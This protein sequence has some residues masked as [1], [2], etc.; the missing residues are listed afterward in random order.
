MNKVY[1]VIWSEAH[2]TWVVVAEGTKRTCKSSSKTIKLLIAV[3]ATSAPL[4][5]SAATLP[6]GGSVSFGEGSIAANGSNQLTIKQTSDKLGI[7]WQSFNI[8]ADG[9]VVFEQ[10]GAK[11]VALNRVLGSDGSSIMGKLN[12][13]GQVFIINPNGI[14]FGKTAKVNVGGLVA[15]TL[16][17]SDAD[18]QVVNYKFTTGAKAGAVVNHGTLQAAEGGYVALI[19]KSVQNHGTIQARLGTASLAAGDAVT[20]DFSGDGLINLRV[21]KAAVGALVDNHGLIVADGGKVLMTARAANAI[22]ET[23]VNND[24]I[25]QAQ[26][27][28]M[29]AGKIMLDGG[30]V[31]GA[32]VVTVGGTLDASAHDVGD[33]GFIETSG[34]TV[35]VKDGA[36]ITTKAEKG[37]TGDWLID[38]TDFTVTAGTAPSTASGIGAKT[39]ETALAS[40][41]VTL[42]TSSSGTEDGNL[43]INGAFAW[44]ANT[45]LT[46]KAHKSVIINSDVAINGDAGGISI[47]YGL[48]G[49]LSSAFQ[50]NGGSGTL[51]MNGGNNTFAINGINYIVIDDTTSLRAFSNA[52][53]LNGHYVLAK[54]INAVSS[55]SWNGGLGF[56]PIGDATHSFT[57][58][59]EGLNHRITNLTI[60]RPT[61]DY[62]GFFAT[63]SGAKISGLTLSGTVTG[64]SNVGLLAGKFT[65]SSLLAY[66]IGS[67]SY[68]ISNFSGSVAG[69]SNVG[70]VFGQTSGSNL[71]SV[72]NAG[73]VSAASGTNVGGIFGLGTSLTGKY[74]YNTGTI[75]GADNIGGIGGSVAGNSKIIWS[76]NQGSINGGSYVGGLFGLM[77]NSTLDTAWSSGDVTASG[78]RS[79]GLI[80][81]S[82][83]N[84]V[85]KA[86]AT[87]RVSALSR[88]AGGIIGYDTGGSTVSETFATS[89]VS[90]GDYS[91]GL[92][93]YANGATISSSYATGQ[94][95]GANSSGLVSGLDNS[96]L[97]V[98]Y[99]SGKAT[100]GLI[101][102]TTSGSNTINEALWD[103]GL[104]ATTNSLYGSGKTSAQMRS[105]STFSNWGVDVVGT[106]A[107]LWRMYDGKGAPLLKFRL[108]TGT[109]YTTVIGTSKNATYA[110]R[111]LT[112]SD[113]VNLGISNGGGLIFWGAYTPITASETSGGNAIRN[114]GVYTLDQMYSDQF[115]FN[116]YQ[117]TPLTLAVAKKQLTASAAASVSK[118]Y[119]GTTG[120]SFDG[121]AGTYAGDD[122]AIKLTGN[123][124]DKNAGGGKAI[125]VSNLDITGAAAS[126]YL[127]TADTNISGAVSKA[128]LILQGAADD[129]TYDGTTQAQAILTD[130]RIAGDNLDFNFAANFSDKNAGSSKVVSI[131]GIAV[132]GSDAGNY[133]WNTSTTANAT[134][135][136]AVLNVSAH[137]SGKTYDGSTSASVGL[138]DNRVLGDSLAITAWGANFS[139]KNAGNGKAVNV[140]GINVTGTDVGNYTWNTAATTSANIDKAHLV[141]NAENGTKVEGVMDGQFKWNLQSGTLFGSDS[142]QGHLARDAG[143]DVGHYGIHEGDLTAG[144]N[145]ELSVVPGSFEITKLAKP[146]VISDPITPPVVVKPVDP[147]NPPV[148]DLGKPVVNAD[149]ESAKG[150]ISTVS[151]ATNAS[152]TASE[153]MV[154]ANTNTSSILADYRLL[155]LGMKLPDDMLSDEASS[156]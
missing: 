135:D 106:S 89:E 55:S 104:S 54:N 81:S 4:A 147:V 40:S 151:V 9:R 149:L 58:V 74:L 66:D 98:V 146:P 52:P 95:S 156:F 47:N 108:G 152:R 142:I 126:N 11:S 37:R 119:D 123:F 5:V 129:K 145:Y 107:G 27:I 41:N 69:I 92:I 87:G 49:D 101:A 67:S 56:D 12:A 59:F 96:S 114:A 44:S 65:N 64:N 91:G 16:D 43:T 128:N 31:D 28:N 80:G 42:Q 25:I 45:T 78:E 72:Q 2:R 120:I 83:Q 63:T 1:N 137:A 68:S 117:P 38:P 18:F 3:I 29:R 35:S 10:P 76:R 88:Y 105:A 124:A 21:D 138:D 148:V 23:V 19:G 50:I 133:T 125:N 150:I 46:L 110:G 77:A 122:L 48:G 8:G 141:V 20:L 51:T 90:A 132:A 70:G 39:L 14:I 82:N 53:V 103:M 99:A 94:V 30:P 6:Q 34:K 93:G 136:K 121:I 111:D 79:G 97:N 144:S 143:E 17:V 109:G 154:A 33:G 15:S 100:Y 113:L 115:G 140:N 36:V 134:I 61:E 86:Y 116:L 130:N 153:P 13:N 75:S 22:T 131:D 7:N 118:V 155:N 85:S 73:A 127:I 60:K 139:D 26:T 57:G 24:G 84:Q 71:L 112:A 32:G 102:Q 62:V